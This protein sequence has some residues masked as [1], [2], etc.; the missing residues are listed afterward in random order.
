MKQ[1]PIP[2][3]CAVA[4]LGASALLLAGA[5]PAAAELRVQV[6]RSVTGRFESV[7][8]TVT[9]PLSGLD[10]KPGPL[11][12]TMA[13]GR[14]QRQSYSLEPTGRPGEWYGRFTPTREGRYTGTVILDRENQKDIGLVPL[15]R[16]QPSSRPGFVRLHPRSQRVLAYTSGAAIFPLGVRLTGNSVTDVDWKEQ[17]AL[18]RSRGINYLAVSVP[19]LPDAGAQ[20][21]LAIARS[22]DALLRN[23]ELN[24]RPLVQIRLDPPSENSAEA[25]SAFETQT[26]EWVRRWS[27]SPVLAAWEVPGP[28]EGVSPELQTRI[29]DAVRRSDAYGHLVAARGSGGELPAGAQFPL[30]PA[31][32][33][34]PSLRKA[35]MDAQ[36]PN[37]DLPRLPGEASWQMLVL[38]GLGIPLQPYAPGTPEGQAVL[39]RLSRMAAFARN[40]PYHAQPVPLADVV[41][42]DVPG[43]FC[44]YGSVLVG[45]T[46]PEQSG[47]FKLPSI[48]R[49][50][51][52]VQLLN[53]GTDTPLPEQHVWSDGAGTEIQ[54][55]P[56]LQTVFLQLTPA[57]AAPTAR[58]TTSRNPAPKRSTRS[59]STPR[60][61]V[62]KATPVRRSTRSTRARTSTR[63]KRTVRRSPSTRSFS[64]KRRRR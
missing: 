25:A 49:G 35:L 18:L 33:Q 21:K 38:G 17:L 24:G 40:T 32:W 61:K 2:V 9:D 5:E 26:Q 50:R 58:K 52:R 12:L 44:R 41:P 15:I 4:R 14:D 11:Q 19:C 60:K 59:R 54:L 34:R 47:P 63:T 42:V 23:A 62:R 55:P 64:R 28:E 36:T 37:P 10:V 57:P 51:Y 6:S 31:N 27:Y 29:V 22:L 1:L 3:L 8:I 16:V 13:D 45:W 20:E 39:S 48:P 56:S 7:G 53:P 30:I 46:A 43:S